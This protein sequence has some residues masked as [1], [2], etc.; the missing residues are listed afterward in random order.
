M[1]HLFQQPSIQIYPL[2]KRSLDKS[3]GTRTV[4][5]RAQLEEAVRTVDELEETVKKLMEDQ[6]RLEEEAMESLKQAAAAPEKKKKSLAEEPP[7]KTQAIS[8]LGDRITSRIHKLLVHKAEK[9]NSLVTQNEVKS[10][11][12][13]IDDITDEISQLKASRN[14]LR[15]QL[16][17]KK[18]TF[19]KQVR[20]ILG[21]TERTVVEKQQDLSFDR[22][23]MTSASTETESIAGGVDI[24]Y[25]A[26]ELV[27]LAL[28]DALEDL[29]L[30]QSNK[31]L[32]KY[33]AACSDIATDGKVGKVKS[34][35]YNVLLPQFSCSILSDAISEDAVKC[36]KKVEQFLTEMVERTF[37]ELGFGVNAI[38]FEAKLCL[39]MSKD[40]CVCPEELDIID[41]FVNEL[42][43]KIVMQVVAN[44]S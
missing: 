44:Y 13:S 20:K 29:A 43:R 30:S 9:R 25:I 10:V 2:L 32:A 16:K 38:N 39:C 41:E 5:R 33:K 4:V 36:S 8:A 23:S 15:S 18:Q 11:E 21:Y 34:F 7:S 35:T 14:N 27:Y 24:E 3:V 37:E 31:T 19:V 6:P 22:Y 28:H 40:T 26:D 42:I 17:K 1:T 12:E